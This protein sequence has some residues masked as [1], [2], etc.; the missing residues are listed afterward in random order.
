MKTKVI[1]F[2]IVSTAL[3]FLEITG[4]L[5]EMLKPVN[6]SSEKES[7]EE[8]E[9]QEHFIKFYLWINV[10]QADVV[11]QS[12]CVS[13]FIELLLFKLDNLT[14][15][16]YIAKSQAKYLKVRQS[17]L[18]KDEVKVLRDF[19]ENCKSLVQDEIQEYH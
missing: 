4:I 10:D 18:L 12:M 13:E 6:S 8:I 14:V 19:V 11:Q 16:S 2:I 17:E 7:N 3:E 15:H 1:W 9:D 5:E